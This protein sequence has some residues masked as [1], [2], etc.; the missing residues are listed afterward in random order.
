MC[1]VCVTIRDTRGFICCKTV[2][3]VQVTAA[4]LHRSR[5]QMEPGFVYTL[6]L[7]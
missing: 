5:S 4:K 2:A 7:V 3:L 1:R 6:V